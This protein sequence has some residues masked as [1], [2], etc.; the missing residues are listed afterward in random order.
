VSTSECYGAYTKLNVLC[1]VFAL[2]T[3]YSL[4]S[5]NTLLQKDLI[6]HY[7][8]QSS[9]KYALDSEACCLNPI[10]SPVLLTIHRRQPVS[11]ESVEYAHCS[12]IL[13]NRRQKYEQRQLLQ[14][15]AHLTIVLCA[16]RV[17][18]G[19]LEA[20]AKATKEIF[21]GAKLIDGHGEMHSGSE[22]IYF[23]AVDTHGGRNCKH[24]GIFQF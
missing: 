19:L 1:H 11:N 2:Y 23:R 13:A 18:N 17:M 10:P 12:L 6:A 22:L 14:E 24:L 8:A 16:C 21:D 7:D 3:L 5:S 20:K 4:C 15:A 9:Q